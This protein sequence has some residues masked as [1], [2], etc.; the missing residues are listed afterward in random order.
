MMEAKEA[1]AIQY[2][3]DMYEKAEETLEEASLALEAK[4]YSKAES[5]AEQAQ[6]SASKA[7]AVAEARESE[8]KV[9]EV[10][11]DA[12]AN[13]LDTI[14]KAE[15]AIDEVNDLKA[16]QLAEGA[17]YRALESLAGAKQAVQQESFEKAV[18]LAKESIS[19]SNAAMAMIQAKTEQ[20]RKIE[21]I[22]DSIIQEAA[23]I[24]ESITRRTDE[25]IIISMGGD[26]F[27]KGSSQ[28]RKDAQPRVKMV[29]DLLRKYPAYSVVI[30]GHTDSIG[31]DESN[32][33]ISSE[34]ARNFLRYLVDQEGIPLGRLSS[35]GFGESRPIASNIN[36]AGRRQNRRVDIFILTNPVLP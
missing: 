3:K 24:T 36:E 17:Y 13:A 35:V 22:Q 27:T 18:L 28:I 9:R 21:E 31:S 4:E 15:K 5:L 23:N 20:K 8:T 1:L 2:A 14:A 10:Q 6:V 26:L 16:P 25:G 34:R 19:H 33:R 12:E 29:A 7:L 11:E 32:L 30:Q